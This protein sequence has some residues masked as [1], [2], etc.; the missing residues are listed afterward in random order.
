LKA[1]GVFEMLKNMSKEYENILYE[2]RHRVTI[3]TI[4]RP[5]LLNAID[6]KTKEELK[7]AF[8][9]AGT[10]PITKVVIMTGTGKKAFSAGADINELDLF[11]P[12]SAMEAAEKGG[13]LANLIENLG[14]PT[15]AAI[16][17]IALG[18]GLELAL[19]FT[20][21]IASPD[22]KFGL[23]EVGLGVMPGYGGGQRL[24][25]LVGKGRAMEILL[26]AEP[27][28]A[29][30]AYRIGLLNKI[31]SKD[32]FIEEAV[33]FATKFVEKGAIALRFAM[34]AIHIGLDLPLQNAYKIESFFAALCWATEDAKEGRRAFLEK[35]SPTFRDR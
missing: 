5:K 17:G 32:F 2:R 34:Q 14:K 13:N 19:A 7:T 25:R 16:N 29:Q 18:G 6:N 15:I 4:N 20:L 26:S 10:D 31:F 27:I 35:R 23:P 11:D 28:D 33:K 30:E 22:S 1:G 24:A 9:R 12:I 21:R 3:I 8:A